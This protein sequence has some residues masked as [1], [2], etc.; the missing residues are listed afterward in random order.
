MDIDKVNTTLGKALGHIQEADTEDLLAILMAE[1]EPGDGEDPIAMY[2]AGMVDQVVETTKIDRN[3]AFEAVMDAAE[4]C[5]KRVPVE[6]K[7]EEDLDAWAQ[8]AKLGEAIA[9]RIKR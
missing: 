6:I 8:K 9:A 4:E 2:F 7:T 5:A 1:D 3:V